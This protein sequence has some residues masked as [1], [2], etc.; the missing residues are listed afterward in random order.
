MPRRDRLIALVMGG[1]FLVFGGGFVVTSWWMWRDDLQLEQQ[2]VRTAGVVMH[3]RRVYDDGVHYQLTYAFTDR[4]SRR[5]ETR[6]MVAES[7]WHAAQAGHT[8]PVVFDATNPRRNLPVGQ[9]RV[10]IGT[11]LFVSIVGS[12]LGGLGALVLIGGIRGE[13]TPAPAVGHPTRNSSSARR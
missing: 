12:L 11:V 6:R 3:K 10:G 2:G 5:H 9:P 8:L 7:L 4:A 13:E 1:L